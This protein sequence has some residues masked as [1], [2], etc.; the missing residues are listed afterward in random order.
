MSDE[1]QYG[2]WDT[3]EAAPADDFFTRLGGEQAPAA[4]SAAD[5]YGEWGLEDALQEDDLF[6]Q[7]GAAAPSA[8]SPDEYDQP[9]AEVTE[10]EDFFASLGLNDETAQT[11]STLE[12]TDF[13]DALDL[14][15][16]AE[17]PPVPQ[18]Q[19]DLFAPWD[20]QP[21]ADDEEMPDDFFAALGLGDE[22]LAPD[23]SLETPDLFA[24]FDQPTAGTRPPERRPPA[25]SYNDVDS[26]LASLSPDRPEVAPATDDLFNQAASVDIDALFSEPVMP[27]RAASPPEEAIPAANADWL[28]ELEASVGDVSASAIVRQKEDRPVEELSDRLRKLRQRGAEVSTEAAQQDDTVLPSPLSPAPF[29]GV[30]S[31]EVLGSVALTP[32][33]RQ[34]VN[35][36]KALV[37]QVD[38][39]GSGPLSAI[40]ATYDSPFMLGLEDTPESRVEPEPSQPAPRVRR[41]KRRRSLHRIDRVLVAAVIALAVIL[42]FILPA[43]RIGNLPP[44]S[45]AAG[46]AAQAAFGAVDAL[47]SGDLVLIGLEYGPTAAAE[48][49]SLTDAL[50]RHILLRAAYP[51]V[52]SGNPLGLLRA[53]N[54]FDA[55]SD[56]AAFLERIGAAQP[57]EANSDYYLIRYLAG[58]LI[59][60]RV[61]SQD[62][63]NMLLIDI[64]GQATN[65]A[66][67]SLH[68][69]RL[70]AVVTDRAEDLRAYAEQVA[71]LAQ[72]PL[73]AAVSYG[74]APLAEP[75]ARALGG[76]LLVGYEDGYTYADEL[77]LVIPRPITQRIRI[78]PT[79]TPTVTPTPTMT[80]TPTL[81]LPPTRTRI[82]PTRT[83]LPPT[84]TV[85]LGSG[86]VIARQAVNMRSG[87]STDDDI[88]AAVPS[89]TTLIAL[90]Y[91]EDQSWVNVRLAD[92][93]E[94]WIS[95]ALLSISSQQSAR[96]KSNDHAKRQAVDEGEGQQPTRTPRPTQAQASATLVPPTQPPP[97]ATGVP[98]TATLIQ[99]TASLEQ[100]TFTSIPATLAQMTATRIPAT[101]AQPTATPVP[102]ATAEATE[103][104]AAV[105][106]VPAA[107]SPGYR[108]ERWYA[109]NLGII[110]SA[111][112]ITLGT[113]VNLVRGLLRRG[114]RG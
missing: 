111:L 66:V 57:L 74:A 68:E 48:L 73:L 19:E 82:P 104:A 86:T 56:D 7:L 22:Q 23:D 47:Q 26:Y 83:P 76:G 1:D 97:S 25:A 108:D 78:I 12:K 49:D 67:R 77:G 39:A 102:E 105:A 3:E 36:L 98:P 20:D 2:Q 40:E 90:R 114:R 21:A 96:P 55:I 34:K 44:S 65:L 30:S 50:V 99:P 94:G 15:G 54:L 92:G 11:E 5:Q 35:L 79:D 16:E 33:Q 103:V 85:V 52:I 84:P 8:Y 113:V 110:A 10:Q 24:S 46:S 69:F 60:L 18:A 62:S 107:P 106:G 14:T 71:P 80:L 112:V 43:A 28:A 17:A 75:Y 64:R 70:V 87:P 61:F 13:F 38:R 88:I 53:Q 101:L 95:A 93:Q 72:A 63:A 91:N 27:E 29:I 59:G 89:G 6:A 9:P 37:P 42:P 31:D 32:D 51:V 81:T 4:A 41:R 58:S 45:F 100:P 109:M